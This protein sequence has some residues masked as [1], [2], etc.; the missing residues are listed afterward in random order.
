MNIHTLRLPS[1]LLF[2]SLVLFGADVPAAGTWKQNLAHS[3]YNP[4]PA[5]NTASTLR[6]EA[7]EGGEQLSVDGVGV[8]GKPAS[9]SYTATYDGKPT[10]VT[11][12]PYGDMVAFKRIDGRRSQIRYTGNGKVTRISNRVISSDGKTMTIHAT[13]TSATGQRYNNVTVFEKQ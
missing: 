13:G 9:W 11:G 5:P 6:I 12:S 4:G 3:K 10:S 1:G 2:A 7:V 8:D